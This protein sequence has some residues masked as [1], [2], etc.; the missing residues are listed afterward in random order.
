MKHKQ[1]KRIGVISYYITLVSGI[2]AVVLL[3][4]RN[5][6]GAIFIYVTMDYT[7]L[8]S[9]RHLDNFGFL[10]WSDDNTP[11]DKII[12]YDN[13]DALARNIEPEK[14]FCYMLKN[15]TQEPDAILDVLKDIFRKGDKKPLIFGRKHLA[16]D[17]MMTLTKLEHEY[18]D[19]DISEYL[20]K[21]DRIVQEIIRRCI[22]IQ[23][24]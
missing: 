6:L 14:V 15:D 23:T 18:A 19:L 22:N 16:I 17:I 7:I 1:F 11:M 8:N 20:N 4:N 13:G 9:D 2:L 5:I 12:F 24:L 10:Y 3:F 21:K